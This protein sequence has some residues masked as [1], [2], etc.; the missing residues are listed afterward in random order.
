MRESILH[1]SKGL[2]EVFAEDRIEMDR[3][4][5]FKLI[6]DSQAEQPPP[7]SSRNQ[8]NTVQF[9]HESIRQYIIQGGL[10][11]LSSKLGSNVEA[12]SHALLAE[13]CQ[14]MIRQ[15]LPVRLHVGSRV[16]SDSLIFSQGQVQAFWASHI[17]P[18]LPYLTAHTFYHLES[19]YQGGA[20]D[21]DSLEDFPLDRWITLN[22][23]PSPTDLRPQIELDSTLPSLLMERHKALAEALLEHQA[24]SCL[25][26]ARMATIRR[27]RA[28][29]EARLGFFLLGRSTVV[30][31]VLVVAIVMTCLPSWRIERRSS[32]SA[33]K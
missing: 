20:I 18:L 19:A 15:P 1:A 3:P 9:I 26:R 14:N 12:Q 17:Y 4:V 22:V 29:L 7:S 13:Y 23:I 28:W 2:L 31:V 8:L 27:A 16:S 32:G 33:D 24:T 30:G 25:H 10:A 6:R 5:Y 21:V 11:S